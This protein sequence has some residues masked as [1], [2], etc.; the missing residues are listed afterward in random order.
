MRRPHRLCFGAGDFTRDIGVE[1]SREE[2]GVV[3]RALD[4]RARLARGRS[5]GPIDSVFVDLNDP[6]GLA[7]STR[8]AKQLG[9]RGKLVIHPSQVPVVNAVF[10]PTA[11]EVAWARRVIE[12]L[13]AAERE[14]LGAFVVDGRM[15]DYPIVE[16]ARDILGVWKDIEAAT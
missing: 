6:D 3:H 5:S 16:R 11:E 14:G 4:D 15:V 10:T 12:A 7:A 9:F 1:W 13:A 2:R 8:E